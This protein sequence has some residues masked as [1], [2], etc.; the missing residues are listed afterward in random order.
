[1]QG[2]DNYLGGVPGI[3]VA[4]IV[5][6]VKTLLALCVEAAKA[7]SDAKEFNVYEAILKCSQGLRGV[8][9]N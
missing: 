6:A 8:P 1:M 5:G 2:H 4:Q 7:G 9:N 3:G